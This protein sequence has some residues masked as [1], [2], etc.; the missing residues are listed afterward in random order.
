MSIDGSAMI[1]Q[2]S[3]SFAIVAAGFACLIGSATIELLLPSL[4]TPVHALLLAGGVVLATYGGGWRAAVLAII[5]ASACLQVNP[6]ASLSH[7]TVHSLEWIGAASL[8]FR[9]RA[10]L[11][12]A[13]ESESRMRALL[14]SM[15]DRIMILDE[16]GTFLEVVATSAQYF[17]RP[18]ELIGR[19]ICEVFSESQTELFVSTIRR[20]LVE[21]RTTHIEYQ[22]EIGNRSAWLAA[23]VSPLSS[24]TVIW[25]A[26]DITERKIARD[27]M[28]EERFRLLANATS[29]AIWDLD[30]TTGYVWRGNGYETLFGYRGGEMAPTITAWLDLVHP[31]DRDRLRQSYTEAFESGATS[32]SGEYRFRRADDSYANILENARI[33]RDENCRPLR[34]VGAMVDITERKQ[35]QQQVEQAHRVTSLGRVAAS[36]AHEVNNVLMGIQPS[37]EVIRRKA[38]A[39]LRPVSENIMQAVRRGKRITDE[40]LRFTRPSEPALQCVEVASF[41]ERWSEEIRPLL[42][43]IAPPQ[44]E[45][46]PG[47]VC[48]LA[49]ALQMMQVFTN[50]AINARDAM[51]DRP[52]TLR[53]TAAA[54][55]SWSAFRFG[56]VKTPDRFVHFTVSDDGCGIDPSQVAHI[57]EPLFTTKRGG[58]GLGLAITYQVVARHNGHIFVESEVGKGTTFHVFLPQTSPSIQEIDAKPEPRLDIRRLLLVEDEPAVAS[59]IAT[60]LQMEE[61]EVKILSAGHETID[62]IT[63]FKPEAVVLDIGLPDIDGVSVYNQIHAHWPNLPVLFSSG[64]GDSTKLEAYLARPNVGFLLKPYDFDAARAALAEIVDRQKREVA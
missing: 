28:E 21:R 40:I 6:D 62:A 37:A 5:V 36:I 34:A 12:R 7:L 3:R 18:E 33:I 54:A 27:A 35:L 52:G 53:I 24:S 49:D 42:D 57:F 63:E 31:D 22:L 8:T 55:K 2:K 43:P 61:I 51:R 41:F 23:S 20:A 4:G 64:H 39:E 26:R 47:D 56:V 30:V 13:R 14:A 15:D 59:G 16:E 1:S 19:R 25:V 10:G 44:I 32:W 60:L 29:D 48:V 38:P 50:L 46:D 58:I 11:T 45:C 9:L 17:R